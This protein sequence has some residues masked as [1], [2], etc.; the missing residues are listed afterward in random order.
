MPV[1]AP[2]T[3]PGTSDGG[4]RDSPL[5]W[6]RTI[7]IRFIQGLF[8]ASPPGAYHWEPEGVNS[9]IIITDENPVK[10]EDIGQRPAVTLTRGPVQFYSLG[11]DD[12][13]N[14]NFQTGQKQKSVIV[15]GT[16]TVNCISRVDIEAERI[17]WII[18]EQIWANRDLIIRA[19]F[20]EVGRQPSIG[21]PSPAGSIISGD[22]ADEFYAVPVTM[23][24]QFN[25]TT[26]V[27]PLGATILRE[28]EL[29][30]RARVQPIG[31]NCGPPGTSGAEY[32]TFA[33]GCPPPSFAPDAS[34]VNGYSPNPGSTAPRLPT[35]PHPLNPAQMVVVR[36]VRPSCAAVRPPSI[37]GRSIPISTTIVE[38]SCG[39][40][41][42]EHVTDTST[43]KV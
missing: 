24:F 7:Y 42:D 21:S 11:L 43:V 29:S 25:R 9:E 14:Y 31:D 19:G 20:F 38:E 39:K 1:K 6:V 2:L 30:L 32:P 27:T 18:A 28:I 41:T 13:M 5:E 12:M 4:F 40:Q 22:N 15:P 10:T 3:D 17:A 36:S 37:G 8:G 26:A 34:D 35:V 33:Q 23:P 16:V